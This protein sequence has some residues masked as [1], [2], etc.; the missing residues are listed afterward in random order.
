[1]KIYRLVVLIFAFI[2]SA[3]GACHVVTAAGSGAHTGADWNNAFTKLPATLV[4]GDT[5]YLADGSYGSYTFNTA[6]TTAI[7]IFKATGAIGTPGPHC[8]DTG[9]V[10]STMGSSSAKFTQWGEGASSGGHYTLTG[11]FGGFDGTKLPAN[12]SFGI[13]VSGSG[14]CTSG[15]TCNLGQLSRCVQLDS[16]DSGSAYNSVTFS[17]VELMGTGATST[18]NTNTP[19]DLV[20]YG[21]SSNLTLDHM[22]MHDSSCDFTFGYGST[23]LTVQYSYFYKNWG[24]GACHGQVAWNGN[25]HTGMVWRYN[26]FRTIEGTAVITAAA[27]GGGTSLSGMQ[28]YG[29]TFYWGG[30]ADK[31]GYQCLG[32][33]LISC[34][35]TGVSCSA[36]KFYNNTIVGF[37]ADSSNG[38]PASC[39][40]SGA[41]F[42]EDGSATWSGLTY[43]NNL[44]YGNSTSSTAAAAIASVTQDHNSWLNNADSAA[45]TAN[46]IN[47]GAAAPFVLW[48]G[49][50]NLDSHLTADSANVNNW[51]SLASP[52]N[53]DPDNVTRTTDRGAYQFSGAAPP[54][55]TISGTV[56]AGAGSAS[57]NPGVTVSCPA[58]TPTSAT[59]DG[60]GAYTFANQTGG[61]NYVLTPS[62]TGY[63]FSPASTTFSNLAA[64]QTA[65]F[66]AFQP[67]VPSCSPGGG[68]FK[69]GRL[70]T[71]TNAVSAATICWRIG[72]APTTNG[73]GTCTAGT[74]Y[75]APFMISS[76]GTLFVIGTLS[77]NTVCSSRYSFTIN[78]TWSRGWIMNN[79]TI[80]TTVVG[81]THCGPPNYCGSVSLAIATIPTPPSVGTITGAGTVFTDPVYGTKGVRLTDACFDPSM[82]KA[83]A[84]CP[85]STAVSDNGNN[86]YSG[87][88]SGSA[89][90]L[91]F[92]TGDFLTIVANQGGAHYLVGF[93]KNTLAISRPYASATSGCPISNCSSRGGWATFD[94]VDMSLADPCKLYDTNNTS[95]TSYTFGSDVVPFSNPCS[96]LISGPPTV[97][98]VVNMIEDSPTGCIGTACNGLPS[99]FGVP[100]WNNSGG[101]SL[102]DTILARAFSSANYYRHPAWKP[103]NAYT[104]NTQIK[105][106]NNNPNGYTFQVTVAGTSGSSEPNWNSSCPALNNTCTDGTVTWK[107]QTVSAGQGTGIYAVIYSPTKGVMSYN[108]STGAIQA[109]VGWAGG[110]GLTCNANSCTG[111]STANAGAQFTIHNL[112]MNKS[113]NA[114]AISPTYNL[115]GTGACSWQWIWVPGTTTVYCS[116]T[117]RASGHWVL[118][119]QG[120]INDPGSPLYQFY[121]RLE[122]AT[123]PS[124]TPVAVNN[125]PSPACT[126]NSDQHSSYQSADPNDTWPFLAGRSNATI[127]NDGLMPFDPP[128]CPWVNE[129]VMF[130]MNG[131]G[132]SHR[133]AFTFNTGFSIFFNTQWGIPELSPSG[134]FA[135][136]GSDWLDNLRNA[137]G[138]AACNGIASPTTTC[139]PNGPTWKTGKVYPL[140]Y[141]INPG[142]NNAGNFSYR[143]TVAGTSLTQPVWS[144]NCVTVGSTCTDNGMT[145]TNIGAPTG[146][147]A[148]GADAFLWDLQSAH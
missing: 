52:F 116:Q 4:R 111:T 63:T 1:M 22:Y 23:N 77:G 90:D 144:T 61:G 101:E 7:T 43:E 99:D 56:S 120:L 145:W 139:I 38:G 58:C 59:T 13:C 32:N 20:Y 48:T 17:F 67:P 41:G 25:T 35:N 118:G 97:A 9:W 16:V 34:V 28:M 30:T 92:N 46:V 36:I 88:Q 135:S 137:A 10:Q 3:F 74:T 72:S 75:T 8:T 54:T 12:G 44:W 122:P 124:G 121:Y 42:Y 47:A 53:L 51:L 81:G 73:N 131:D 37:P 129:L 55:F 18:A 24:A 89:D 134:R 100:T 142:T 69:S 65:N 96:S 141:V 117:T 85:N 87:S 146:V 132:L 78:P 64:N 147:N 123:G 76:T 130:D 108:T 27:A 109:D 62:K 126:V 91:E 57:P 6:G 19:D 128:V 49:S 136:S 95:I 110:A 112:K 21:G 86:S 26:T 82:A 33:G 127:A 71:C 15:S 14:S 106:L 84:P 68:S 94:G 5:Y 31:T 119:S 114:V 39:G 79:P 140:N 50:G 115:S 143:V 133:L 104:L 29:N 113:G 138:T 60:A 148:A 80:G 107:N 102:G 98:T 125:L 45:G 66:T 70:I 93:D 2:G 103:T 105:P 40:A 83:S 11:V